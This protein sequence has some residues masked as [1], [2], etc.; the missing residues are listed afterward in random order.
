MFPVISTAQLYP[1]YEIDCAKITQSSFLNSL[2]GKSE[3]VHG[4]VFACS[5]TNV[6]FPLALLRQE[7]S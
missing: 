5:G 2:P 4:L 7:Q 1:L 6:D 3:F